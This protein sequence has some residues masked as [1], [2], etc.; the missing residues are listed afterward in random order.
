MK[1]L[2]VFVFLLP[3]ICTSQY[4]AIP[5]Q[6][7]EQKLIDLGHDTILDGQV[8]TANIVN[9]DSLNVNG[10]PMSPSINDLSGIEDFTNLTFLDC[11]WHYL[12]SLDVSQNTNLKTLKCQLT[13]LNSL[14][15]SQNTALTY[16]DCSSLPV[17]S[18]QNNFINLDLSQNVLLEYLNCASSGLSSLDITQNNQLKFLNTSMN[19]FQTLDISQNQNLIELYCVYNGLSTLNLS[20]NVFLETLNCSGNGL[21]SLDVSQNTN[22][23]FL[24]CGPAIFLFNSILDS[25]QITSLDVSQNTALT[26]LNCNINRLTSLDV[27]QNTA[28]TYLNCNN[29]RLISLDVR[30]GNNINFTDFNATNNDSLICISVDD[31]IWSATNWMD[32]DMIANFSNDCNPSTANINEIEKKL[33]IYPNPTSEEITISVENFNGGFEAKLYSF[34]GKLLETTNKTAIS[35]ADYPT[36]IYLLK[37]SYGDRIEEVKVVKE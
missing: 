5:D 21:S 16:L 29:N 14:D 18:A 15:L 27:S 32:I 31:S 13:Y 25:N 10:F 30:N 22:L 34:T 6:V 33:S 36:G 23:V 9:L 26:Y 20:Q 7:F 12:V 17:M 4:T 1:R 11:G 3:I 19:T 24:D 28:L 35:L 8:L 37:V 2:L